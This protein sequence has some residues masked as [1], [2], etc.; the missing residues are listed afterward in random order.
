MRKDLDERL[1]KEFPLL[2][3]DRNLGK[4]NHKDSLMP[5]GF[6]CG[7]GWF[8]L[9]YDLSGEL[10]PIIHSMSYKQ[11]LKNL[12][13]EIYNYI[14]KFFGIKLLELDDSF[15]RA[16][17]VKEKFGGLRFYIEPHNKEL[18][19]IIHRYEELSFH[20]CMAC[21]KAGSL[22]KNRGWWTTSC[23]ECCKNKS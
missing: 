8:Q 11:R 18:T 17:Q 2:Y 19:K 13:I 15:P 20:T 14:T 1:V 4:R 6:S 10:E 7:D 3:R 23:D 9:I 21:G 16:V 22:R 12:F 5:Y